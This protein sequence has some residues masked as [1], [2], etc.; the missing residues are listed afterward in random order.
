M[1]SAGKTGGGLSRE[2]G[3]LVTVFQEKWEVVLL[4]ILQGS[5]GGG[6]GGWGGSS[7]SLLEK[8]GGCL[9]LPGKMG[10]GLN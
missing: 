3:M 2:D 7:L 9:N 5:G 8:K 1:V 6:G 10:S 4:V